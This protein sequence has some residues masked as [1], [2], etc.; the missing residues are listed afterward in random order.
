VLG[1]VA[2]DLRNPLGTILMQ[3]A[4]LRR[5]APEPERRSQEPTARLERAAVRMNRLIEDLLDV[6]RIEAGRLSVEQARLPAGQMLSDAVEAQKA[7]AACAAVEL[8]L[9]GA[10]E[11][12]ELWADRHRLG[13]VFENLIGNAIKFTE[14][15]G[16]I[17]VG[18]APGDGEALFWVADTGCGVA[19]EDLPHLFDRFWQA[20][21]S[22][23]RSAGLGLP[24]VKGI[25]EAHGGRIWVESTPGRGST[26]FFTIPTA[27]RVEAWRPEPAPHGP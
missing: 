24:I 16:R 25:V 20:R 4:L 18:A 19:A 23:R 14:P 7:L 13:Q 9:E 5:P 22:D 1:I 11:L 8:R 6:T 27:A 3:T 10:P 17:T 21:K 15:G 2:H 26:F 12:P